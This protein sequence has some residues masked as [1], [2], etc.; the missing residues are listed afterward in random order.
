MEENEE[1]EFSMS[2]EEEKEE[3]E[4]DN[5]DLDNREKKVETIH[6]IKMEKHKIKPSISK[7]DIKS[8]CCLILDQIDPS[9][10]LSSMA[11]N[12]L[13]IAAEQFAV[14]R[15]AQAQYM[16]HL[17]GEKL[18]NKTHLYYVDQLRSERCMT[19]HNLQQKLAFARAEVEEI[20]TLGA[21]AIRERTERALEQ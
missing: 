7:S 19:S 20:E 3:K 18:I 12:N 17:M 21:H 1:N 2:F 6:E 13:R 15:I 5:D 4:D 16:C 8:E 14:D 9:L 10:K 11:L